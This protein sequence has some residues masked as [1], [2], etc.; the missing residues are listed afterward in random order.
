LDSFLRQSALLPD[1]LNDGNLLSGVTGNLKWWQ[2]N[3]LENPRGVSSVWADQG[4]V[5]TCDLAVGKLAGQHDLTVF[6]MVVYE[7]RAAT[8]SNPT[9]LA[10]PNWKPATQPP[11]STTS[12]AP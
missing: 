1:E 12:P 8:G 10:N 6:F 4:L 5:A 9:V 3:L 11:A 7:P 2:P